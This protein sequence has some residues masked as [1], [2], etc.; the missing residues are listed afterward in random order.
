MAKR[1]FPSPIELLFLGVTQGPVIRSEPQGLCRGIPRFI[2]AFLG[3]LQVVGEILLASN[4]I[5]LLASLDCFVLFNRAISSH[6]LHR[7]STTESGGLLVR[8]NIGKRNT[9]SP[10]KV[11]MSSSIGSRCCSAARGPFGRTPS[12]PSWLSVSSANPAGVAT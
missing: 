4:G 1:L 9:T 5:S 12:Y 8:K 7:G 3:D 11:S 6:H 10:A 2:A